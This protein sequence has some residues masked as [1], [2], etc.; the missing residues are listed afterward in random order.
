MRNFFSSSRWQR[1]HSGSSGAGGSFG[2]DDNG[3]RWSLA[4]RS[5][6]LEPYNPTGKRLHLASA[7]GQPTGARRSGSGLGRRHRSTSRERR[8]RQPP[9]QSNGAGA[10]AGT[11]D[12]GGA[13][14]DE[15]GDDD[16]DECD[17][18]RDAGAHE[19]PPGVRRSRIG[20]SCASLCSIWRP[21]SSSRRNGRGGR[22][23]GRGRA[24]GERSAKSFDEPLTYD[25][26]MALGSQVRRGGGV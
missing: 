16:S 7:G 10:G 25:E 3:E 9:P 12:A 24:D 5:G 23:A 14:R 22:R 6:P 20:Q 19:T 18:E 8:L 4:G 1:S 2:A 21:L 17:D 26:A 15:Y 11:A 13:G